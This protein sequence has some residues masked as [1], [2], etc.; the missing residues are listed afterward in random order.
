MQVNSTI[1]LALVQLR[2]LD[3]S[4]LA[5]IAH[6]PQQAM[7]RWVREADET[8]LTFEQQVEVLNYLGIRG[9][10]PRPDVVHFWRVHEGFFSR[11][12]QVYAPLNV[13][14]S[15]FGPAEVIHLAREQDAP[16]ALRSESYFALK[17][18]NFSATLCVST[19]PLRSVSLD[20]SHT[21][22]LSWAD[23]ARELVIPVEEYD[24]F[25]P[26]ALRVPV[27][28]QRLQMCAEQ[29][30]WDQLRITA[31]TRGLRADSVAAVL[32]CAPEASGARNAD[33]PSPLQPEVLQVQQSGPPPAR[34]PEAHPVNEEP[35]GST[36]EILDAEPAPAADRGHRGAWPPAPRNR[37]RDAARFVPR[38]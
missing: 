33:Q 3:L 16:L 28:E 7:L 9:E 32:L 34:A 35:A 2:E 31:M 27:L 21:P 24:A 14:L 10:A 18:A 30:A 25:E 17:F 11:A 19:H 1:V 37:R 4:V 38:G 23:D 29:A 5:R 26:G 6:V 36:V 13:V 22:G 20:P 15:A 12:A 8:A